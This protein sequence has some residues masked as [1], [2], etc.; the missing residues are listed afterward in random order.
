MGRYE[1]EVQALQKEAKTYLDA[2][3]GECGRCVESGR[4]LI[5]AFLLLLAMVAAQGRIAET[6]DVFYGA[7]DRTSEGA[8]AANA[9]KRSVDELDAATTREF[10]SSNPDFYIVRY[11]ADRGTFTGRSISNMHLGTAGQDECL[12]PRYQRYDFEAE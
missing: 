9:Y 10:V 12:F 1:K 6:I 5:C 7:A 3:R 8:M 11:D 4:G 2:M